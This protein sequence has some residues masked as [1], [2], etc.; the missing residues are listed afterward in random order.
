MMMMQRD[1]PSAP[2]EP[3]CRGRSADA[4]LQLNSR[5]YRSWRDLHGSKWSARFAVCVHVWWHE[6]VWMSMSI[7]DV[8]QQGVGGCWGGRVRVVLFSSLCLAEPPLDSFGC[9][10]HFKNLVSLLPGSDLIQFRAFYLKEDIYIILRIQGLI[11]IICKNQGFNTYSAFPDISWDIHD[12][13]WDI[14]KECSNYRTVALISHA[15]KV[16]LKI[17]QARLQQY[18]NWELPDVQAGFRKGRGS[19]DQ[20]ANIRWII[21]KPREFQ[22][23]I[24][25]IDYA[26]AFDYVDNKLENSWRDGNTRP[27]YLS[28]EK[29]VCRSRSNS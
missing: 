13:D 18:M 17:L 4:L 28:P 20:I 21:E 29:P 24:C 1:H 11:F 5:L 23:N 12:I 27:H 10:W 26:K 22:K 8:Q 19:R 16:M 3:I 25:F 2:A 7:C 9:I 6:S 14:A 15:S